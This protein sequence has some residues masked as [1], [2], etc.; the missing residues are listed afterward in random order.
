M[1]KD[2]IIEEFPQREETTL[3]SGAYVVNFKECASCRKRDIPVSISKE[4]HEEGHSSDDPDSDSEEITYTHACRHCNH[5]ICRHFY[6]FSVEGKYQ[7]YLMECLLCGRGQ[8]EAS[9]LPKDPK[10]ASGPAIF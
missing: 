10:R 5:V 4:K 8:Y 9:Y 1:C 2:C 7:H 3:Q 6:S